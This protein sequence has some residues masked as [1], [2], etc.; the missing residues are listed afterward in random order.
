[1]EARF[2]R[3][4]LKHGSYRLCDEQSTLKDIQIR[5]KTRDRIKWLKQQSSEDPNTDGHSEHIHFSQLLHLKQKRQW[6]IF[7]FKLQKKKEIL[8]M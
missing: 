4:T 8:G 1:M 6:K 5:A 7:T 2:L 3:E